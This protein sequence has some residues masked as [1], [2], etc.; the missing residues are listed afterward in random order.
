VT[1]DEL[2]DRRLG[3][4]RSLAL[5][6]FAPRMFAPRMFALRIYSRELSQH[7]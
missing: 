6:M 2:L 5:R 3:K 1:L 7:D 4:Q